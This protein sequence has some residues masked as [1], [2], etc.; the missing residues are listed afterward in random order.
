MKKTSSFKFAAKVQKIFGI[1]KKNS[2]IICICRFFVV[3]L[4][5]LS[6][7]TINTSLIPE[8]IGRAPE[9]YWVIIAWLLRDYCVIRSN[10]HKAA[11][12][13]TL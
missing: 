10:I 2:E 12:S 3:S 5:S 13:K 8:N 7:P 4:H 9:A 1:C 6:F 11:N